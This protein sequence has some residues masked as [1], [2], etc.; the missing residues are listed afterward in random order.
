MER[1]A[2]EKHVNRCPI[3][4]AALH[5]CSARPQIHQCSRRVAHLLQLSHFPARQ[6][7][8]FRQ[9]RHHQKYT[10]QQHGSNGFHPIGGQQRRSMLADHHRVHHQRKPEIHRAQRDCTHYLNASQGSCFR[11]VR[12]KIVN[13]GANLLADQIG[14]HHFH[15]LHAHRILYSHQRHYGLPENV[16]LM[17]S[18]QVRLQPR[19]TGWV[20]TRNRQRDRK[21]LNPSY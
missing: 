16:K 4:M 9:V 21:H 17:E 6:R 19:P 14:R 2:I 11:S 7:R 5:Q 18:L 1:I 8:S 13:H 20:R 10:R 12:G 15:A 3:Q